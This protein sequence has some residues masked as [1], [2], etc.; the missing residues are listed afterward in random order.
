MHRETETA[1]VRLKEDIAALKG[2]AVLLGRDLAEMSG[3]L[4]LCSKDMIMRSR[5]RL[6]SIMSGLQD[7]ARERV[8]D[9]SGTLKEHGHTMVDGCRGSIE[10]RPISSIAIAFVTGLLVASLVERRWR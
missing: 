7:R 5:E 9:T 8:R 1:N 10:R 2:D 4:R 6:H 3:R